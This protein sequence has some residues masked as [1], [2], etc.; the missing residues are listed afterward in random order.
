M[1]SKFQTA[2]FLVAVIA[3]SGVALAQQAKGIGGSTATHTEAILQGA[4]KARV[5]VPGPVRLRYAESGCTAG[6]C[7]EPPR[8]AEQAE[9]VMAS[10]ACSSLGTA[11]DRNGRAIRRLCTFN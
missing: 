10:D 3:L 5:R 8:Q 2:A 9:A 4:E 1:S 11:R 6:I 7:S